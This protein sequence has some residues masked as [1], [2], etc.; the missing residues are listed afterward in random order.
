MWPLASTAGT[1][2]QLRPFLARYR[3]SYA[4]SMSTP[5]TAALLLGR[6]VRPGVYRGAGNGREGKI[7][8]VT[9]TVQSVCRLSRR[10]LERSQHCRSCYHIIQ[11]ESQYCHLTFHALQ[12][13]GSRL[14]AHNMGMQQCLSH[15]RGSTLQFSLV[16]N[17]QMGVNDLLELIIHDKHQ[18]TTSTT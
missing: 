3:A 4:I 17:L 8:H 13:F 16:Q 12:H 14:S 9:V 7:T 1:K 10:F 2:C 6:Q 5:L 15:Q 11:A 18:S